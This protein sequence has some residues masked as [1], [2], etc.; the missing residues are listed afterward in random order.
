MAIGIRILVKNPIEDLLFIFGTISKI[1]FKISTE[2]LHFSVY[3]DCLN[4]YVDQDGEV[5]PSGEG[6]L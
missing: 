6:T 2:Y 1:V 4:P 3:P 5:L